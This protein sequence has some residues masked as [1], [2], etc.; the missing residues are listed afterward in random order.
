M[1][2]FLRNVLLRHTKPFL[3]SGLYF[4]YKKTPFWSIFSLRKSQDRSTTKSWKSNIAKSLSSCFCFPMLHF[5][6]MLVFCFYRELRVLN[7]ASSLNSSCLMSMKCDRRFWIYYVN[8]QNHRPWPAIVRDVLK[9]VAL[10]ASD[11]I[12]ACLQL[13]LSWVK[14][15]IL[16]EWF[17]VVYTSALECNA[18]K[19][20]RETITPIIYERG[21][22]K[23]G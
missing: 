22:L 2:H 16:K 1:L 5:F 17:L 9:L 23:P 13:L 4:P 3:P 15:V 20:F 7:S 12:C 11:N 21:S 18:P 6:L 8:E 10:A 19:N 14:W